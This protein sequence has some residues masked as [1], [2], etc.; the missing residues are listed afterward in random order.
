[1]VKPPQQS[2]PGRLSTC[3]AATLRVMPL[4][5]LGTHALLAPMRSA[6]QTPDS[7]S[8]SLRAIAINRLYQILLVPIH[9]TKKTSQCSLS[10]GAQGVSGGSTGRQLGAHVPA[11]TAVL[12][13]KPQ[14][15]TPNQRAKNISG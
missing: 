2:Q 4:L 6:T 12:P 1:M 15:Q 14:C 3:V 5:P 9:C 8:L 11:Y 13:F 7:S 10:R